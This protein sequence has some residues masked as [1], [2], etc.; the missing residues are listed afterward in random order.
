MTEGGALVARVTRGA[1][2]ESAH[3]GVVAVADGNGRLL[4]Q[5]GD[6]AL[7]SALRSSAKPFQLLPLVESGVA[8]QFG[9]TAAELAVM[10]GSHAGRP[11]HVE[12]VSSILA[13]A[14]LDVTALRCGAHMPF[15]AEAAETLIKGGQLPSPLHNNC[16]GKHAAMLALAK[17][18]GEPL[19]SYLNP[20]HAV[21][22]IIR[23][24]LAGV[25]GLDENSIGVA[26]DGCSA[27]TFFLPVAAAAVAFG[28]LAAGG[29]EG[30]S[31]ALGRIRD[32]MTS[33]PELVSGPGRFDTSAMKAWSGLC[34]KG[35]AEGFQG[36]A[37]RM[38]DGQAW[39]VAVKI[40]DG[41]GR[42]AGP[43]ALDALRQALGSIPDS[44]ET[45]RVPPVKNHRG[46]EVGRLEPAFTLEPV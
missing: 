29:G 7:I 28:R 12:A 3:Q 42:A 16:S 1:F 9:F 25:C 41:G 13:K 19:D 31:G 22:K 10:A 30:R 24:T 35:G 38:P 20:G 27:P 40:W 45:L 6:A 4:F 17:H 32:A 44:L 23:S 2:L 33:H 8:D 37:I 18:L 11:E 15:D 14:E 5:A 34:S 43:V 26:T 46:T 36:L 21:Q 39:G